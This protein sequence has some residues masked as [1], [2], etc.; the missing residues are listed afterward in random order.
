MRRFA[1]YLAWQVPGWVVAGLLLLLATQA[2]AVSAWLTGAIFVLY[3][4]KDL[5]LYPAMR[6]V[7]RPPSP[8]APVGQRGTAVD[9]LAPTGYVRVGGELWQARATAG[10]IAAGDDVVVQDARDLMLLVDRPT[11]HR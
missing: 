4:A 1:Q 5:V 7:F 2:L 9:R 3:I 10:E 8:T 11:E 6:V